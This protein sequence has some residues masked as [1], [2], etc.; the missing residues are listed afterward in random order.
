MKTILSLIFA[1][2]IVA[3]FAT[4]THHSDNVKGE[5][6]KK[7]KPLKLEVKKPENTL[8]LTCAEELQNNIA[9]CYG[10]DPS[11]VCCVTPGGGY[12]VTS[13][14]FYAGAFTFTN[15]GTNC[16]QICLS[17]Y[18]TGTQCCFYIHFNWPC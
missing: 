4:V 9:T 12:T 15:C 2:S 8:L 14:T 5:P 17:P 10:I 7:E 6:I 18:G 11:D 16:C 13:P 1:F 3:V